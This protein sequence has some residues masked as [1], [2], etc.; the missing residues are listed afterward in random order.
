MTKH[1]DL[2]SVTQGT[3]KMTVLYV[4]GEVAT[5]SI[6]G[7]WV[8]GKGQPLKQVLTHGTGFFYGAKIEAFAI[9]TERDNTTGVWTRWT[10]GTITGGFSS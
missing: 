6:E 1:P 9:R 10:E 3:I 4:D 8:A 7:S 2:R 5:G